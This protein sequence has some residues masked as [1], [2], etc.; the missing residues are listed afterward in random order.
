MAL[1]LAPLFDLAGASGGIATRDDL[2]RLGVTRHQRA[3]L[4]QTGV[5]RRVTPR[6]YL[7]G[8]Q[9][10][11]WSTSLLVAQAQAGP[12]AQISHAAAG[13]SWSC[14]SIGQGAVEVTIPRSSRRPHRTLGRVHLRRDLDPD[15]V[16]IV[17]GL[18]LT[19]PVRTLFDLSTR[20]GPVLLDECLQD[21]C[22]RGLT[23]VDEVADH[24]AG[25]RGPGR[26]GVAR[27]EAL[28]DGVVRLPDTESWLEARF[29]RLMADHGIPM[30]RT[31]V[32]IEVDGHR[33]RVD[34]L[35]D[36]VRLVVELNG[37]ATHATRSE[38]SADAER[39]A[40]L[41]T[42][43]LEVVTFTHD[44][45][46]GRPQFVVAQVGRRVHDPARRRAA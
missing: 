38:T 39:A 27:I 12:R 25:W 22:R 6:V 28:L 45:V 43:G 41:G 16:R 18:R 10:L 32:V 8:H 33:Y 29:L 23:N 30:P 31:Q 46:V 35:W 13:S 24:L 34:T 1:P 11:T 36:D 9:R 26:A 7:V 14:P 20:I 15:D 42:V 3:G 17:G 4:L 37:Y 19:S 21:L 40:R 44:Q 5:L 2:D